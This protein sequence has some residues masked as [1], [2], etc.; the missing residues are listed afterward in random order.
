MHFAE[1]PAQSGLGSS[2]TFTVGLLHALHA[3]KGEMASKSQ[4]MLEA[5][6]IEQNLIRENVGSQD[7]A[8]AAYGGFNCF[9]FN[10]NGEILRRPVI[11]EQ[12]RIRQLN[13]NLILVFTGFSRTA[14]DIAVHQ[15]KN[16]RYHA[17]TNQQNT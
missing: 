8:A 7:Q 13:R 10:R 14:S 1:I 12:S 2:S 17:T 15:I 16:I 9:S 4:L 5:I 3:L 6:N 11:T